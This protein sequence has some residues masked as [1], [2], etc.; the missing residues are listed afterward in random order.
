VVIEQPE[1]LNSQSHLTAEV[2][3]VIKQLKSFQ[4]AG[5]PIAIG[6]RLADPLPTGR[7][8]NAFVRFGKAAADIEQ[9]RS[10]NSQS[11]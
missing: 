8:A 10:L 9:P 6:S 4:Q 7:Q 3:K 2:I 1:S 5:V 11:H